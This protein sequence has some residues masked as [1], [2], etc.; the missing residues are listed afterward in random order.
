MNAP[1]AG[2]GWDEQKA[3]LQQARETTPEPV[4]TQRA[5]EIIDHAQQCSVGPWSDSLVRVM[6]PGEY[7]YV[8]DRWMEMP[9]RC[10]FVDAILCIAAGEV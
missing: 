10:S 7:R 1:F 5:L 4:T 9:P 3:W 2:K 8:L 6:Y